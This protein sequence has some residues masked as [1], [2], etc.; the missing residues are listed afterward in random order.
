MHLLFFV[1]IDD[2]LDSCYQSLVVLLGV[3]VASCL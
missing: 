2:H 1:I 3:E